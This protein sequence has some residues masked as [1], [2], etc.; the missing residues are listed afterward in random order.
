MIIIVEDFPVLPFAGGGTG[1]VTLVFFSVLLNCRRRDD[2][3]ELRLVRADLYLCKLMVV[4]LS[5]S[6][7]ILCREMMVFS[8][9]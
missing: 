8:P 9:P 6:V 3:W 2:V 4:V 7:V 1:W 5:A